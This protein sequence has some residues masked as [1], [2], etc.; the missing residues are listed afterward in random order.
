MYID[1][2]DFMIGLDCCDDGDIRLVD[3]VSTLRGAEKL[4]CQTF[5]GIG[6][7]YTSKAVEWF[8]WFGILER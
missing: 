7:H 6:G 5:S 8:C 4:K 2:V 1:L 3:S